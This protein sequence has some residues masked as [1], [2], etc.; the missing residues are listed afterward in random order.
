MSLKWQGY[1]HTDLKTVFENDNIKFHSDAL[2][3]FAGCN[4]A[5][6]KINGKKT[7]NVAEYITKKYGVA[8]IGADGYTSPQ[9]SDNYRKADYNFYLFME[10]D[11]GNFTKTSLG[12]ELSPD[13]IERAMLKVDKPE[14]IPS[15]GPTEINIDSKSDD[16]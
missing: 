12:K 16:D 2:I 5:R 15:K 9:G 10:D 3:L 13:I 8:T 11:K 14:A 6:Q 1:S 4:T 7:D